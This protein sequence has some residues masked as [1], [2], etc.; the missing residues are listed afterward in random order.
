MT[1]SSLPSGEPRQELR[2]HQLSINKLLSFLSLRRRAAS[3]AVRG[4]SHTSRLTGTPGLPQPQAPS[5]GCTK[6]VSFITNPVLP[7][8]CDATSRVARGRDWV[9]TLRGWPLWPA[10][11]AG[12]SRFQ[13]KQAPGAATIRHS[14]HP[15]TSGTTVNTLK[16]GRD[17]NESGHTPH[18]RP[19]PSWR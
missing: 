13:R 10:S 14:R 1:N 16:R 18:V 11:E 6:H 12:E 5:G 3:H 19:T 15:L 8:L 7:E 17:C 9:M 2:S 4:L